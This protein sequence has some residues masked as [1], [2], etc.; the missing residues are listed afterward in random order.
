M[1]VKKVRTGKITGHG[2]SGWDRGRS[3]L[4][5]LNGEIT[6]AADAGRP[7]RLEM[8][9]AEARKWAAGLI[10]MADYADGGRESAP[11][12][13]PEAPKGRLADLLGLTEGDK[14]NGES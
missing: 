13:V 2:T 8:T 14:G 4:V 12:P 5:V 10:K 6:D 11:E 7:V 1:P 3:T 9:P